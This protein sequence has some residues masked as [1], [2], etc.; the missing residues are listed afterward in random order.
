MLLISVAQSFFAHTIPISGL[1]RTAEK[2]WFAIYCTVFHCTSYLALF[3]STKDSY[4][5]KIRLKLR[6]RIIRVSWRLTT[7]SNVL[8]W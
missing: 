5:V 2:L 4:T 8:G 6:M 1:N 3:S 7:F